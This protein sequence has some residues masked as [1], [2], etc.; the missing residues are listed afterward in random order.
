[1]KFI[2]NSKGSIIE[3]R[4]EWAESRASERNGRPENN[5]A[6]LSIGSP[7]PNEKSLLLLGLIAREFARR[8][9]SLG[10]LAEGEELGSNL[11]HVGQRTPA[12]SNGSGSWQWRLSTPPDLIFGVSGAASTPTGGYTIQPPGKP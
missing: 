3:N 12:S 10:K 7:E 8:T 6:A 11:L 5:M 1:M 4:T 2:S 9:H